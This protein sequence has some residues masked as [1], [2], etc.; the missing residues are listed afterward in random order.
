M[1]DTE[2]L[3]EDSIPEVVGLDDSD[4]DDEDKPEQ[5]APSPWYKKYLVP[6]AVGLGSLF[7][8]FAAATFFSGS[9]EKPSGESSDKT[10]MS[11]KDNNNNSAASDSANWLDHLEKEAEAEV[12]GGNGDFEMRKSRADFNE[13]MAQMEA[14]YRLMKQQKQAAFDTSDVMA[15]LDFLNYVHEQE[16]KDNPELAEK[17]AKKGGDVRMTSAGISVQDSVDTLN[18]LDREL[19]DLD[20]EQKRIQALR[21]QLEKEQKQL[22]AS[23]KQIDRALAR[24]EQAES[25]RVT[26][27]ARLYD[28]MRPDDVAKLFENLDD[29]VVLSILPKMKSVNAAKILGIMPPKRAARI[30][31]KMITVLD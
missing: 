20:K 24:I 8:A 7:L 11:A 1:S 15:Q 29:K 17:M 12:A 21:D 19:A 16:V 9:D 10:E 31:T 23:K 13:T 22:E 18:W 6:I 5:P 2:E 30:S 14:E 25:A 26:K 27:L 3:R 4:L 28:S